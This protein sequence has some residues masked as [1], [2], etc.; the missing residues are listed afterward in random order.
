MFAL[1]LSLFLVSLLCVQ[2]KSWKLLLGFL[3]SSMKCGILHNTFK[4]KNLQTFPSMSLQHCEWYILYCTDS[5][6]P[7]QSRQGYE[8]VTE[9]E[10]NCT[11]GRWEVTAERVIKHWN[12]LPREVV[13]WPSLDGLK[14]SVY[15]TWG[16]GE[17]Q[18]WCWVDDWTGW[19][20]GLFQH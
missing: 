17:W 7:L 1:K 19:S 16:Q 15:S 2:L 12:W 4:L 18:T 20:Q 8:Q 6:D 9:Q 14:M 5:P 11:R 10:E 3:V 13:E